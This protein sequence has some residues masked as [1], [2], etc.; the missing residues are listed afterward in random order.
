MSISESLL[1]AFVLVI[2]RAEEKQ[3]PSRCNVMKKNLNLFTNNSIT[4]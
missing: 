4:S 3:N 1:S 2:L